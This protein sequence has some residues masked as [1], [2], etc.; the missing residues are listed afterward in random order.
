MINFLIRLEYG[1]E[2]RIAC[3]TMSSSHVP[4]IE[5]LS[6][7]LQRLQLQSLKRQKQGMLS[8]DLTA[9]PQLPPQQIPSARKLFALD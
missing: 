3:W 5:V 6:E 8:E 2:F 7:L 1:T 9:T 4:N